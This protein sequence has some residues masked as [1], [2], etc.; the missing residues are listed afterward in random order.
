MTSLKKHCNGAEYNV[1]FSPELNYLRKSFCEFGYFKY[2]EDPQPIQ[3]VVEPTTHIS[4]SYNYIPAPVTAPVPAPYISYSYNYIPAPVTAPVPAPYISYSYNYI[5]A[6]VP[7]P[8]PAPYIQHNITSIFIILC[9]ICV[10]IYTYSKFN[11]IEERL[12]KV[13]KENIEL[14]KIMDELRTPKLSYM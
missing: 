14:R 8:V 12:N 3:K 1:P 4:Y 9:C 7:E 10:F 13:E 2:S 5:P 6:P 11:K